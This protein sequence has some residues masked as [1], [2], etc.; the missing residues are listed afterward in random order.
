MKKRKE[1][2]VKLKDTD[3][4]NYF[5][6]DRRVAQDYFDNEIMPKIEEWNDLYNADEEY[7]ENLMPDL[8]TKS[9]F[10]ST[11]IADTIEYILPDLVKI[12]YGNDR[13]VVTI[14]GRKA[15]DVEKAEKMQELCN[16]QLNMLNKGFIVFYRWW[17]DA[18]RFGLGIVKG[19]WKRT[20][21]T[22]EKEFIATQTEIDELTQSDAVDIAA[23]VIEPTETYNDVGEQLFHVQGKFKVI[24]S[25]YPVFEN[26]LPTEFLF[27]PEGKTTDECKF[28]IHKKKVTYDYLRQQAETG[29]YDATAVENA[30]KN[31][32][33]TSD[34]GIDPNEDLISDL[35][36]V[37][38]Y[39]KEE[40]DEARKPIMLYEWYTKIDINKDGYLEDCIITIAGNEV[41]RVQEDTY[42]K[43]PFFLLSGIL[44]NYK[45]W[46]KALADLIGQIQNLKTALVKQISY[47]IGL[48]N[49]SRK[50]VQEDAI[51]WEDIING[52]E[53]VRVKRGYNPMQVVFPDRVE[54]LHP[55]TFT[56]LDQLDR[57]REQKSGINRVKQGLD[58]KVLNKALETAT[59]T[60]ALVDASNA[61]IELIARIGAETGIKDMLE[62]QVTSNQKFITETQV[63]RLTGKPMEIRPED[64]DGRF[65]Y[66]VS[67][68]LGSGMKQIRMQNLN[69]LIGLLT[70]LGLQLGLTDPAKIQQAMKEIILELG[71]KNYS[72][73]IYTQEE[74][75]QNQQKQQA[76]QAAMM[77][78]KVQQQQGQPQEQGGQ[79]Q[80]MQALQQAKEGGGSD[81]L[82]Q[83]LQQAKGGSA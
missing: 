74:Y 77:Q 16:Y 45:L 55:A 18:L 68:G 57:Y 23:M 27:D 9:K 29:K 7:Y 64:L 32:T 37:D 73:F 50:F 71:F 41:L 62:W 80:L 26:L 39:L 17:K 49:E 13:E 60:M 78:T 15:E 72:R 22:V 10:R 6:R 24:D 36:G 38:D 53:F 69:Q 11:D 66:V 5:E 12:F 59:G 14:D 46:G 19:S 81:A 47:N 44:D 79:D 61:R 21:K 54:Q 75:V 33:D 40:T 20:Y 83:A 35:T 34:A 63:I 1:F 31:N 48:T 58:H 43:Y 51:R 67:A 52:R 4:L 2:E 70:N 3:I 25:N 82:M 42:E 76:Q 30:I 28:T 65:D 56:F 8:S